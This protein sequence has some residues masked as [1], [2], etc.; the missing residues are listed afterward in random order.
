MPVY[1][2]KSSKVPMEGR[3]G[4]PAPIEWGGGIQGDL[5][6]LDGARPACRRGRS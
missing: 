2:G 3:T 6:L 1:P 4:R 5:G